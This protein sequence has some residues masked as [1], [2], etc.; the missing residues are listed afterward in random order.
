MGLLGD[1]VTRWRG[2]RASSCSIS[3]PAPGRGTSLGSTKD[4]PADDR[5]ELDRTATISTPS[6]RPCAGVPLPDPL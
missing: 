1:G 2:D 6:P 3:M 5:A 4:R